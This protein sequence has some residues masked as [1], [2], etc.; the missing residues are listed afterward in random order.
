LNGENTN[1]YDNIYSKKKLHLINDYIN[2]PSKDPYEYVKEQ[3][4]MRNRG[5]EQSKGRQVEL[6]SNIQPNYNTFQEYNKRNDF[7]TIYDDKKLIGHSQH[8][9][10]S[11]INSPKLKLNL[12][13]TTSSAYGAYYT[14]IGNSYNF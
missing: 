13:P 12:L 4:D 6:G 8:R 2:N 1:Y 11:P 7:S 10:R 14:G 3:I 9:E 5:I